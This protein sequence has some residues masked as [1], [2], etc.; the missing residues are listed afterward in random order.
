MLINLDT[1][2][3]ILSINLEV[4]GKEN[5]VKAIKLI[6]K[7][8]EVI[9]AGPNYYLSAGIPIIKPVIE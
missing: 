1:F 4:T 3:R 5:V 8:P 2:K 6:E 9:Y 7:R